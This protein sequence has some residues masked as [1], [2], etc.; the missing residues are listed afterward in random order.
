VPVLGRLTEPPSGD[1]TRRRQIPGWGLLVRILARP[2][3][4]IGVTLV[5]FMIIVALLA[6]RIAPGDPFHVSSRALLPPSS[7]HHFGTDFAGRDEFIEVIHG[8]RTS[9]T[10]MFWVAVISGLIGV[11]V[12]AVA[13]YRAGRLVDRVLTRIVELFQ[14]IP[15]LFLALLVLTLYGAK[16]RNIILTLGLTM[17]TLLARVVRAETLSVRQRDYVEAARASGARDGRIVARHVIPNILPTAI[18]LI[19]LNASA[20]ILLEAGLAFIGLGD[21]N[22][23]SL[24]QLISYA[25]NYL[26][27][28]WWMSV[29][30]GAALVLLVLGINLLAD[31]LDDVLNP[32]RQDRTGLMSRLRTV[33]RA[34]RGNAG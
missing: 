5:A 34:V 28:A 16:E 32:R 29:F 24:G 19:A 31:A 26:E 11:A 33:G 25:N 17:W 21:P 2:S 22:Q 12:G 9:M 18:V 20:V 1:A 3:G 10:V 13:G 8:V 4:A 23:V 15:R 7:I 14:T 30:P 27:Q 6:D